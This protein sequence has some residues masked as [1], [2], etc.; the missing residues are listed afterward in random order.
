M[1][2]GL[3][4]IL[5][6]VPIVMASC[7][8]IRQ[9]EPAAAFA[10]PYPGSL[11]SAGTLDVQVLR[12]SQTIEMTNTSSRSFGPSTMWL[13]ADYALPIDGFQVGETLTLH[14]ADFRNE[15]SERFRAGGFFAT[16]DPTLLVLAE[17]EWEEQRWG[18]V[19]ASNELE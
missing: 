18:L 2:K 16:R 15:F 13:N 8:L 14:L 9:P 4:S 19:V 17:I 3:Q 7:A 5:L 11:P 10:R 12:R 1:P 6:L